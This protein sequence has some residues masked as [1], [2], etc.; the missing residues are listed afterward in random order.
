VKG[1]RLRRRVGFCPKKKPFVK[2]TEPRGCARQLGRKSKGNKLKRNSK[3]GANTTTWVIVGFKKELLKIKKKRENSKNFLVIRKS[4]LWGRRVAA[5]AIEYR[6][7]KVSYSEETTLRKRRK[8]IIWE[9]TEGGT[10]CST[11]EMAPVPGKILDPT[12]G[13]VTGGSAY[14][15]RE[16]PKGKLLKKQKK[17]G[18]PSSKEP[19]GTEFGRSDA[20]IYKTSRRKVKEGENKKSSRRRAGPI[21]RL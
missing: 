12:T 9:K 3:R 16:I 7:G 15:E 6:T 5:G 21:H 10:L 11:R 17:G 1:K 2:F 14:A 4:L 20:P 8:K 19:G 13:K 18:I